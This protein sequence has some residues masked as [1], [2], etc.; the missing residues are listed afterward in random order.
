MQIQAHHIGAA[1][2]FAGLAAG[3]GPAGAATCAALAGKTYGAASVTAAIDAA[4]PYSVMNK[5]PQTPVALDGAFCRVE[6][7]IKPTAD[8]D[9]KFEVW[10]PPA[11]KW[12]GKYE[13]VGN[14]GFAGSLIYPAMKWALDAGYATSGTDTGHEGGSLDSQ[15]ALGHPEKI[16]DFGWRGVH[17]TAVAAKAIVAD[18][19]GKSAAHAY[20][21]GCS[22]GGREALMEAQRFPH[23][24]E[25]IV[26]GSPANYWTRLLANAISDD[27][28][29]TADPGSWL[30]PDDL[31]LV[32]HATLAACHGEN[33]VLADPRQCHFDSAA[34]TCK[35]GQTSQCLS[36]AKVTALKRIY[37]GPKDE[38]G[39]SILPGFSPGGE[40]GPSA[41]PLWVTGTQPKR[42]MGTLLYIFQSGFYENM[43]YDKPD[44]DYR[45][46]KVSE[47]L[48][49]ADSKV[50]ASI[51]ADNSDLGAFKSAGGKLIQYHGWNDSAIPPQSSIRYYD[52]VADKMGGEKNITPFYRLFM[53]PGME[54][55]GGGPGANAIGGVFGLPAPK[56]D[57]Q[58]DVVAAL[59]HWVED[60]VAPETLTATLYRDNDPAKGIASERTWR[61]YSATSP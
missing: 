50:G 10:L 11:S 12:N 25:G 19:Y 41:W 1:A 47:S 16:V 22:D 17:E 35:E 32:T 4:P 30:S 45:T 7:V 39:A 51:N 56:H 18:F 40:Q 55:C 54:H 15:W 48:A 53:A 61:A 20:F 33:G 38:G 14:G 9:I 31:A 59:A 52:A 57:A 36:P 6:G 28:A 49:D 23:D 60:G 34:L 27:Q 37:A 3:S 8:S 43:V 58:H 2:L 21:N 46:L 29:L 44:M 24:Y 5:D 13:G 26:A 42:V